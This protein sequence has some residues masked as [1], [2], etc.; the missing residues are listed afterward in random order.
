MDSIY[1]LDL[2]LEELVLGVSLA[3]YPEIA[4]GMLVVNYP[5]MKEEEE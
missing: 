5:E 4:K 2:G 1:D 3:G